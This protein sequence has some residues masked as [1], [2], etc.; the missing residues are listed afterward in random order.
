ML[1]TC[2][3]L[4]YCLA[5]S[6]TI[7]MEAKCDTK[8]SVECQRTTRHELFIT[9]DVRTSDPTQCSIMGRPT[10]RIAWR[11]GNL[12]IKK[13]TPHYTLPFPLSCRDQ[14]TTP[15]FYSFPCYLLHAGFLLSLFFN[16]KDGGDKF[17]WNVGWLSVDYMALCPRKYNSSIF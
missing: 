12:Q 13:A 6:V 15:C 8:T 5:Y 3:Q 16:T 2:F 7:K 4:D 10:C 17:L 1:A 14:S 11:C 9:A